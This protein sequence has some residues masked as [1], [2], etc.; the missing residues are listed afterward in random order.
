MRQIID[1]LGHGEVVSDEIKAAQN[2][3]NKTVG[4]QWFAR[5]LFSRQHFPLW[6]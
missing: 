3:Q 2:S 5:L 6:T 4:F 1:K